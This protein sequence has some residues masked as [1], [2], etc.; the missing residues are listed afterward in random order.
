MVGPKVEKLEYS[1]IYLIKKY[2]ASILKPWLIH[3]NDIVVKLEV[4]EI[5]E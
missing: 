5:I 3:S 1:T 2:I 4:I